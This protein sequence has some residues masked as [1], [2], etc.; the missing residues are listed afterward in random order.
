[1]RRRRRHA[2]RKSR[3]YS[4]GMENNTAYAKYFHSMP[5]MQR[6]AA[7]MKAQ[8]MEV[9]RSGC[10]TMSRQKTRVGMTA[11]IRV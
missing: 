6:M 11:G 3:K 8:V 9:P 5:Q 1:M 7:V 4:G 2:V 10:A